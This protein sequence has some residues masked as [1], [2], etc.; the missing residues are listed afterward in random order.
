MGWVRCLQDAEEKTLDPGST[1]MD[2]AKDASDEVEIE[3]LKS[4]M[5]FLIF[6]L[7]CPKGSE[8]VHKAEGDD[9]YTRP[10]R[11]FDSLRHLYCRRD[12]R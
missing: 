12:A 5:S 3:H 10:L 8:D 2:Q 1:G 9:G 11:G 7:K 4:R 6:S